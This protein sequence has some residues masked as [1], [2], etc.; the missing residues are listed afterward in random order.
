M[1][2]WSR[3][4]CGIRSCEG[5][6]QVS[7]SLDVR[8]ISFSIWV[9]VPEALTQFLSSELSML[10]AMERGKNRRK[11]PNSAAEIMSGSVYKY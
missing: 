9:G 2:A 3:L 5:I 8:A 6:E 10:T 11:S 7:S 1:G 4:C